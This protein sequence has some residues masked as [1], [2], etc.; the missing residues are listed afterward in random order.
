MIENAPSTGK[1]TSPFCQALNGAQTS[2]RRRTWEW[3]WLVGLLLFS[4]LARLSLLDRSPPGVRFDELVHI[5][6]ADRI[7]AGEWP[8]YFQEAWGHEP[9]YHYFHA[10]GMWLLGKTVLGVRITSILFGVLGVFTTYLAFRPLFG[11]GVALISATLLAVSLWSLV[12]SRFGDRH[13]SLPAWIGLCVYCFWRGLQTP[14][15]RRRQIVLWF[16]VGG[17]CLGATLYT[18]FASRI[19]PLILSIF[20][21]YLAL[22]HRHMLRGRWIGLILF[23]VLPVLILMPMILYLRQHPELEQRLGQVGANILG[24]LRAWNLVPLLQ[25]IGKTLLMFSFKGDP[26]WLYNISGRPVFDPVTAVA[27]YGGLSLS[28]WHWRKPKH[29]FVLLWLAGGLIPTMFSWPSGSL[30]HSIA[31]QPAAFCFPALF[32]RTLYTRVELWPWAKRRPWMRWCMYG[33]VVAIV[34]NFAAINGYDYYVRWPNYPDVRHEYQAP[35]TAVA[36]YLQ[37]YDRETD[38]DPVLAAVSAPYVDYWN[39]WSKRNFDLFYDRRK[40]TGSDGASVRWFNGQSSILFP[41]STITQGDTAAVLFFLPDHIR[42]PSSLEPD[43]YALLASGSRVLEKGYVDV[44]G[45]TFDLY[46]WQDRGPLEQHLLSVAS[47]PV[48]ASP[49]GPYVAGRSE[50]ERTRSAFPLDVGRRLSLLGYTYGG[51][52]LSGAQA[53]VHQERLPAG[54]TLRIVTYWQV[55]DADDDPLA[56]FGH[57]LDHANAVRAGWDGLHVSTESWQP[58]DLLIQIHAL[59]IPPDL[60]PGIYRVELGV[61]SP[62]THQRLDIHTG[63]GEERAPHDRLLLFPIEIQ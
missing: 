41:G 23:F 43:L 30:G 54:G 1:S 63:P 47:A 48:W 32:L 42:L 21:F 39:P 44:S 34:L 22:F 62:V 14:E 52:P 3:I 29:A 4:L 51:E 38:R 7:Y 19:V 17:L 49:E 8:I 33:L 2:P 25:S 61:Y 24:A 55:L 58:G 35:I 31:A 10:A 59:D 45:A 16:A 20:V 36:R 57:V 13:I 5:K 26:E 6:M 11:P 40:A 60:S 53:Q 18:Y 27:F 9:L 15:A 46:L 28:L 56:I 37:E 50:Q 12:Y